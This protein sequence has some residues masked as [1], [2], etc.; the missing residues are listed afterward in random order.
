M[1]SQVPIRLPSPKI[2][3]F[4][5]RH[6]IRKLAL[7]GSALRQEFRPDS[8][9]DILVE[10]ESGCT[11]G[12]IRLHRMEEELSRLVGGRKVDLV[13]AKFLNPRIRDSVLATAEVQ[14]GER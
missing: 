6:H 9:I 13:T 2:A 3:E 12:F 4:C 11:P 5:K 14:Y 10:F 7:F 8:D 1:P